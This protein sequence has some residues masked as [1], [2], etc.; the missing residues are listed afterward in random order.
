M[1]DISINKDNALQT[2]AVVGF[3]TLVV[4][5]TNFLMSQLSS[6]INTV[7]SKID[8]ATKAKKAKPTK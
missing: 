4:A 3:V 7:S 6:G 1:N 5:G 8:T 2:A